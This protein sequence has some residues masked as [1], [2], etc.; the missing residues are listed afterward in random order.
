MPTHTLPRVPLAL[1]LLGALTFTACDSAEPVDGGAGEE[2][3]ITQ[4]TLTLTP[5]G[6]GDALTAR[7]DFEADG[8]NPTFTPAR[9]VLQPGV[10]YDGAIELRDTAN[11]ED[12]TEEVR[13][14]AEE[15]LLQ[16]GF[17]SLG[18]GQIT[19]TDRESDY[20]SEDENGGDFAVGL[21]FR[22]AVSEGAGTADLGQGTLLTAILY[23]FDD[24]PKTSSTA[25][26]DEIDVEVAFPV[27]FAT[28]PTAR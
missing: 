19:V 28:A 24:A 20:T 9:L 8:T 27:S 6:G 14:E 11:G 26:S 7:A 15:H 4:V 23:H 2:E 1:A 18:A 13:A 12:I 5:Q 22:V 10:T 16:Y 25:T 17:A 21:T 3:L